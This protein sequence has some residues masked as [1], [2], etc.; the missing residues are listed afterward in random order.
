MNAKSVTRTSRVVRRRR[1]EGLSIAQLHPDHLPD[2]LDPFLAFD[3]FEMAQPF[4]PPHPHA[5]FSA[6]TYM[7]PES[8]NGFVNRDSRGETIDIRPGDLHW[9]AAG[10]GIMH[11]EVPIARGVVCHGLQIFVN[12]AAAKKW[13]PPQ[14]LHLD[15]AQVPIVR[16]PSVT[17]RVVFGAHGDVRAPIDIPTHATLLDVV[18]EPGGT[19][20]DAPPPG[21][22]RFVYVI[23]GEVHVGP[24]DA[25]TP[26]RSG[27]VAGFSREGDTLLVR[28]SG[29]RAHVVV[30]GG[31]PLGE[32]TVF[33][34]PFCMTNRT[35]I[36]RAIRDYEAGEM[37]HLEPSF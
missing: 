37:G 10:A 34:G 24:S 30:A 21:E 11:E 5:G 35:D 13:M 2:H 15:S 29:Q 16:T 32:P 36:E 9:T 7:F 4:F 18:I 12:L 17:T 27:D 22:S 14:V 19:F 20:S 3:H 28:A 33:Y 26:L 25:P 8:Q 6:V 23:E 31:V 1:S